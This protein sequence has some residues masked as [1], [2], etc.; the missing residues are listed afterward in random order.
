MDRSVDFVPG[1][2]IAL[3]LIIQNE[4]WHLFDMTL[5]QDGAGFI[6]TILDNMSLRFI[7]PD[8][9]GGDYIKSQVSSATYYPDTAGSD[10][11]PLSI[12]LNFI[13]LN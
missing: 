1:M 9:S 2:S 5:H 12:R 6:N 7:L 3:L 4:Q 13:K 8:V 11:L 10:H